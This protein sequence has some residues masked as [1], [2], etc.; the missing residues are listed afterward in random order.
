MA[1]VLTVVLRMVD[2]V[3][4]AVE[5]VEQVQVDQEEQEMTLLY[6]LLKGTMVVVLQDQTKVLVAA[7]QVVLEQLVKLPVPEYQTI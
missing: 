7:E 4:L 5:Q 6:L 1:E 2:Q 3:A